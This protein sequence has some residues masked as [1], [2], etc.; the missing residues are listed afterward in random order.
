MCTM[1]ASRGGSAPAATGDFERE[2]R[3]IL[4]ERALPQ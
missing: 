3:A 4:V 1:A 2:K